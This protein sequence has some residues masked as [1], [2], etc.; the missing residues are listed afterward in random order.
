MNECMYK[1][2]DQVRVRSDLKMKTTYRMMSGERNNDGGYP[3][4]V[5]TEDMCKLAGQVINIEKYIDLPVGRKYFAM[6]RYWVDEMF[7][8]SAEGVSFISLL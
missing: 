7:V 5:A 1:P 8:R 4:D 2:G 3:H 6:N